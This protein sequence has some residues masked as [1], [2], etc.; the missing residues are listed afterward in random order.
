VRA[1]PGDE[2]GEDGGRHLVRG[3]DLMF[4][5]DVTISQRAEFAPHRP[6]TVTA[7]GEVP[8]G[9]L[10]DESGPRWLEV[11]V[12][13]AVPPDSADPVQAL[14][15]RDNG[16]GIRAE[17]QE[18]FSRSSGACTGPVSVAAGPARA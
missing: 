5:A 15:V 18:I 14:Y 1:R 11:R 16:I 4:A 3:L 2:G 12:G 10:A 7:T 13:R 8:D 17:Q 6:G 9:C